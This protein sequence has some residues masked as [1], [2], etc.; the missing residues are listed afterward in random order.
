MRA[1]QLAIV[2]VIMLAAMIII[3]NLPSAQQITNFTTPTLN[4]T[5]HPGRLFMRANWNSTQFW[6]YTVSLYVGGSQTCAHDTMF[7]KSEVGYPDLPPAPGAS[8]QVNTPSES[9]PFVFPANQLPDFSPLY[10]CVYI[11]D[12]YSET[13][14]STAVLV[15][16]NLIPTTTSIV[17]TS[18]T[19]I[20]YSSTVNYT[21]SI[22]LP[23]TTTG[24]YCA[25]GHICGNPDQGCA[26][27]GAIY[28]CPNMPV[29]TTVAATTTTLTS[30]TIIYPV[31]TV[32]ET[33]SQSLIDTLTNA[34]RPPNQPTLRGAIQNMI[35]VF[36]WLFGFR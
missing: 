10:Y 33:P 21:T 9:F 11:N 12:S 17:S 25:S 35:D 14:N 3:P 5:Y 18:T 13:L 2:A 20:Y 19:S 34:A 22:T 8:E 36:R 32:K 4:V 29:T 7:V 31:T 15:D 26:A 1:R 27:P 28:N 6:L 16:P 30:P 23:A 24:E